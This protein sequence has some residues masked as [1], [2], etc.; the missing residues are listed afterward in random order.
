M[1]PLLEKTAT[2][3]GEK[4]HFLKGYFPTVLPFG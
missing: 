3:V 1:L 2:S 4:R